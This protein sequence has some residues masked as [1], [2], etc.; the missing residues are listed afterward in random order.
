MERYH[1]ESWFCTAYES[2]DPRRERCF[3]DLQGDFPNGDCYPSRSKTAI[4]RPSTI[5]KLEY[6]IYHADKRCE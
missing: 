2:A 3:Q 1:A 6:P 4:H 5:P